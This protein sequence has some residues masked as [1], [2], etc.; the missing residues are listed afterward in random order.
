MSGLD[1]GHEDS[2]AP[3]PLSF[4]MA[5]R[6]VLVNVEGL[7]PDEEDLGLLLQ[8]DGM[9]LLAEAKLEAELS[10]TLCDGPFIRE[11]NS[12]WRGMDKETDVLSFPME[13]DVVLG[14]VVICVEV[15]RRQAEERAYDL[16]DEARVLLVRGAVAWLGVGCRSSNALVPRLPSPAPPAERLVSAS[17]PPPAERAP[18]TPSQVHGLLHLLGYDHETGDED[19]AEMREAE[20]RLLRNLEW[21]GEGLIVAAEASEG[22][23]E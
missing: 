15:A 16:R 14:D 2:P 18:P 13:D 22:G 6:R 4:G 21:K 1:G 3:P 9:R 10:L 12:Q 5:G 11:L 23:G 8:D 19:A 7:G 20:Q 17:Y